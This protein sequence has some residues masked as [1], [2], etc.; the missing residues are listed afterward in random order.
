MSKLAFKALVKCQVENA[1]F[2]YLKTLQN[3]HTKMSNIRYN[4]FEMA[5]Y[6]NSPL[7]NRESQSLLLSLRT[8]TVNGIKSDFKGRYPDIYCPLKCGDEDTLANVMSCRTIQSYDASIKNTTSGIQLEV[9][10][11]GL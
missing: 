5:S 11:N 7:F 4:K 2:K 3:T 1:A 8:R 6:L 9:H 10:L